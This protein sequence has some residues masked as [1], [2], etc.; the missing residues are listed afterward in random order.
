[1]ESTL[2]A[3]TVAAVTQLFGPPAPIDALYGYEPGA[4]TGFVAAEQLARRERIRVTAAAELRGAHAA[5]AAA[6]SASAAAG[7]D[8]GDGSPV[9]AGV[10]E[11]DPRL[12]LAELRAF[13]E[14]DVA[15]VRDIRTAPS[16]ETPAPAHAE[17]HPAAPA[18]HL[19]PMRDTDTAALM[20][21][22]SSLGQDD[23]EP[24]PAAGTPPVHRP[25]VARPH[26]GV[27]GPDH[28]RRKGFFGR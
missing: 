24:P 9:I 18:T 26:P 1:M 3:E 15:P 5:A 4:E 6:L 7:A 17:E 11:L 19:E 20:R 2:Y 12:V 27:A 22:L 16:A 8:A 28:R 21:E 10:Q 14:L 13:S 23:P 25:A